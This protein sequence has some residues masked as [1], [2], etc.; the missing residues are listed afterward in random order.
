MLILDFKYLRRHIASSATS[1]K[2]ILAIIDQSGQVEIDNFDLFFR[3]DK[4]VL[5][6]QI[7]MKNPTL[8]HI[9]NGF[10]D[11]AHDSGD[12]VLWDV[13]FVLFAFVGNVLLKG[14]ALDVLEQ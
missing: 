7:P 8:W 4:N 5:R 9:S 14:R 13:A 1:H 12:V 6:F 11:L 2:Q 3:R 10:E